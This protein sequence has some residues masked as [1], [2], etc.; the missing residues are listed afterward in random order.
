MISILLER[1][2]AP[3]NVGT[4]GVLRLPE[5]ECVSV[6]RPWLNNQPNVSCI[7]EGEYDLVPSR[8]NRGGY[9]TY[10]IRGVPDRSLIK[11]HVGNTALD[12]LGCVALGSSLGYT[13]SPI[14]TGA[15]WGV[16]HSRNSVREFMEQMHGAED[17]RIRITQY[18]ADWT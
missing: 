11:I 6:E 13:E 1:F 17:A 4:F 7:P 5:F 18:K 14:G 8:Y 15:R 3:C 2:Y 10:E 12:V 9:D 16:L